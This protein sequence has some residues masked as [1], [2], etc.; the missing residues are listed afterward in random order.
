MLFSYTSL[1]EIGR[2]RSRSIANRNRSRCGLHYPRIAQTS[3]LLSIQQLLA[4]LAL[5]ALRVETEPPVRRRM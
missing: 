1:D 5:G 4:L 3:R 2:S